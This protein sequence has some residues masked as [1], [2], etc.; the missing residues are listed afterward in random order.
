MEAKLPASAFVNMRMV[1]NVPQRWH[2]SIGVTATECYVTISCYANLPRTVEELKS[3]S[4]LWWS[5]TLHVS[6]R[7]VVTHNLRRGSYQYD[8]R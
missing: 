1:K 5:A 4:P 6:T 3:E 2:R 7:H 8:Y